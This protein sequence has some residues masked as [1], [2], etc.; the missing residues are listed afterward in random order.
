MSEKNHPLYGM[1]FLYQMLEK[2]IS[3]SVKNYSV[4]ESMYS[5]HHFA[6]PFVNYK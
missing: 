2:I 1:V 3:Q 6:E 4:N 5:M